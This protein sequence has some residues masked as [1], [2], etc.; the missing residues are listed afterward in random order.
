M[1]QFLNIYDRIGSVPAEE[2]FF[3]RCK[4]TTALMKIKKFNCEGHIKKLEM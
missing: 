4:F 1:L 2:L 3:Q